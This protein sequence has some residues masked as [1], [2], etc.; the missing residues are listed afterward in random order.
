V[1]KWGDKGGFQR[2]VHTKDTTTVTET[3][4]VTESHTEQQ[5]TALPIRLTTIGH[6]IRPTQTPIDHFWA[7]L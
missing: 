4:K 7:D 6:Y 2:I 1:K 5:P 3:H